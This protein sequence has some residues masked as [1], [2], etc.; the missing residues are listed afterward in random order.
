MDQIAIT[1]PQI[2]SFFKND[3]DQKKVFLLIIQI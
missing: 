1:F 2:F 3:S